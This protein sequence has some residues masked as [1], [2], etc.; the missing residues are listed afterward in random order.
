M[1]NGQSTKLSILN[2]NSTR[3]QHKR[4]SCSIWKNNAVQVELGNIRYTFWSLVHFHIV[5]IFIVLIHTTT[6]CFSEMNAL[7]NRKSVRNEEAM[8]DN[9]KNEKYDDKKER[10]MFSQIFYS[11]MIDLFYVEIIAENMLT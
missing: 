5:T 8:S 4:L 9:K 10:K 7:I 1:L 11:A 3:Q 6:V 2:E